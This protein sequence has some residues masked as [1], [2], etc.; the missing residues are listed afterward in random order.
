MRNCREY[1][2]EFYDIGKKTV[3]LWNR[4]HKLDKR[5]QYMITSLTFCFVSKDKV[6]KFASLLN[7]ARDH[8]KNSLQAFYRG[9]YCVSEYDYQLALLDIAEAMTLLDNS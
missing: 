2:P 3:N 7:S 1:W 5:L 6:V 9:I 8:H 4:I